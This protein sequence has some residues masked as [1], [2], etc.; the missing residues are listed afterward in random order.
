MWRGVR[1]PGIG[2]I[3]SPDLS[4]DSTRPQFVIDSAASF[5]IKT[6]TSDPRPAIEQSKVSKRL[7]LFSA[8]HPDA[9]KRVAENIEGYL[10]AHPDRLDDTAYTL[11]QRR[12]HLKQR[13]YAV[14]KDNS[15]ALEVSAPVK[16]QNAR[17]TAFVFTG[18]G[19]QWYV[20][21][22]KRLVFRLY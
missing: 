22:S 14:F 1:A 19:A 11:A 7:L 15:S 10:N 20:Y 6:P 2:L 8:N 13:S 17:E 18:Q 9:L 21:L 16:F 4:A 12:E 5:G 3:R